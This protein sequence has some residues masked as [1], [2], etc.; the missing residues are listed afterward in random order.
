[1]NNPDLR[2]AL[3][4]YTGSESWYRHNLNRNMLYT[5]GVRFFAEN[6]GGGAYWFLDIIATEVFP[7]LRNEPFISIEMTVEDDMAGIVAGDG[8]G[9]VLWARH[10]EFTDCPEGEWRFYLTD[11]VLL[12]P[13]EY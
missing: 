11:N 12:L 9:N 1:M 2:Q 5:D 7:L 6:A 10:I 3:T 13:T 8:N 4:Q